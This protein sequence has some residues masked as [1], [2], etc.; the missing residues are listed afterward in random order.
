MPCSACGNGKNT[1]LQ[2][3]KTYILGA[4]RKTVKNTYQTQKVFRLQNKIKAHSGLYLLGR[5][6]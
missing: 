3:K 4:N 6:R 1:T 2:P 5:R